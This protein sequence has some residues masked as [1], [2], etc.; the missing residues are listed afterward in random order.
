MDDRWNL[1]GT[2]SPAEDANGLPNSTGRVAAAKHKTW[3][4]FSEPHGRIENVAP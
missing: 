3:G 4:T 1:G 2:F